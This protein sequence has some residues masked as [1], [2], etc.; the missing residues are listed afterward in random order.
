METITGSQSQSIALKENVTISAS[1]EAKLEDRWNRC[2]LKVLAFQNKY[3]HCRVPTKFPED[4]T[5]GNWVNKQRNLAA[6]NK[7]PPHRRQKLDSIGFVWTIYC[8]RPTTEE[9]SA[10]LCSTSADS[11]TG[12][13]VSEDSNDHMHNNVSEDSSDL[14]QQQQQ[15]R[16]HQRRPEESSRLHDCHTQPQQ[17]RKRHHDELADDTGYDGYMHETPSA[18]TTNA[19]DPEDDA[20]LSELYHAQSELHMT[21]SRINL[22]KNKLARR[23]QE[24]TSLQN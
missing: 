16:L 1:H 21:Y 2:Y 14:M 15:Q 20:I 13:N 18:I 10:A 23:L 7:L 6:S 12:S 9:D 8:P 4:T 19:W 24:R 11:D 5:L 17:K 22:L 3:G